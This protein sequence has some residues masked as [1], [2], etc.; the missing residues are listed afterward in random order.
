MVFAGFAMPSW[1]SSAGREALAVRGGAG[2]FDVSHMGVL[3]IRGRGACALADHLM[4]N[5]LARAPDGRAVYSPLCNE[6]GGTVDDVIAYK[7][8]DRDVMMC[9]NAANREKDLA[10]IRGWAPRVAGGPGGEAAGAAGGVR[11]LDSSD[12]TS[13]LALQGPRAMEVLDRGAPELAVGDLPRFGFRETRLGSLPVL[14]ARTG[15]TGEDGAEMFVPDAAAGSLW[16]A[17]LGAGAEPCGLAARDALRIEARLPLY[18]AE[19]SEDASPL[20]A[21]LAW[22]VRLGKGDFVGKSSLERRRPGRKLVGLSLERGVPRAGFPVLAGGAPVGR[23]TSGTWS[24]TLERGAALAL[25]GR[26]TSD[27]APFAI[28]VR[29][30]ARPATLHKEPFVVGGG[31]RRGT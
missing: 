27:D 5:D 14:A 28:D 20:D 23:V 6:D 30:K 22:A 1:Y 29:G 3:R 21:G 25:V 18:G 19:L 31:R 12:G 17:L 10:W 4:T 15:Y 16:D 11:V 8:S 13:I 26:G 9:V 2:L 24:P 7:L